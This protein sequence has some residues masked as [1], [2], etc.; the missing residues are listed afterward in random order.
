MLPSSTM[1]PGFHIPILYTVDQPKDYEPSCSPPPPRLMFC[2]SPKRSFGK[3][4]KYA[5]FLVSCK[6][7]QNWTETAARGAKGGEEVKAV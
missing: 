6:Y 3:C 5:T 7:Q 2:L 1:A 4:S